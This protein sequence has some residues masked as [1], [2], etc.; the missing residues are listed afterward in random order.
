MAALPLQR[1]AH[2][3]FDSRARGSR[4]QSARRS[5]RPA[6]HPL[7]MPVCRTQGV[8]AMTA[9]PSS[10]RAPVHPGPPCVPSSDRD[11]SPSGPSQRGV[12]VIVHHVRC[13]QLRHSRLPAR[14]ERTRS[15][16][17]GG[18]YGRI[19]RTRGQRDASGNNSHPLRDAHSHRYSLV[20]SENDD[21]LHM[22]RESIGVVSDPVKIGARR[23]A[24]HHN[25]QTHVGEVPALAPASIRSQNRRS[26]P[27]SCAWAMG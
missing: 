3:R 24:G 4:E 11:C 7:A 12:P 17:L 21:A 10:P 2:S 22:T 9:A 27:G 5:S 23:H 25:R 19:S 20:K 18:G 26:M 15:A 13:Q 14:G 8:P 16:P 6:R 1:E